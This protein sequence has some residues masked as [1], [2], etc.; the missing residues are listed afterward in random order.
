MKILLAYEAE[1]MG[2]SKAA[3]MLIEVFTAMGFLTV[4]R[5]LPGSV[6]FDIANRNGEGGNAQEVVKLASD[7]A[8][9]GWAWSAT[10]H[11]L[12]VE[13]TP[14]DP[15]IEEFNRALSQGLGMAPVD[16]D[17]IRYGSLSCG[18]TNYVLR[19]IGASMPSTCPLLSQDGR[20]SLALL[21]ER[22]PQYADAVREGLR[23]RTLSWK[24]RALYP[25]ALHIMQGALN[26][27]GHVQRKENE[28]QGL[29]QLHALAS[30]AMARGLEP[31]WAAIKRSVLRTRPPFAD[32]VDDMAAFLATRSGGVHGQ[33]LK[34]LQAF[35]RQFVNPSVRASVPAGLYGALADFPY[36]YLAIAILQVALTC[37]LEFVKHGLCSWVGASEV[38]RLGRDAQRQEELRAAEAVLANARLKLADTGLRGDIAVDNKLTAVFGRLDTMMGRFV[39]R[40]A[41]KK[42]LETP[43][44]GGRGFIDD[45]LAN[46]PDAD[47]SPYHALWPR[48][49]AEADADNGASRP[50]ANANAMPLY[51]VDVSGAVVDPRAL[52]RQKGFE[53][54]VSC[55]L[56]GASDAYR[57]EAVNAVPPGTSNHMVVL[58]PLGT[59]AAAGQKNEALAEFTANWELITARDVIEAHPGW[60]AKYTAA[61]D[62][63]RA[64]VAKGKILMAAGALVEHVDKLCRP[65]SRLS[66]LSKPSRA[67]VAKEK[68]EIGGLVLTPTTTSLKNVP[69]SDARA[70]ENLEASAA[71]EV[72]FRPADTADAYYLLPAASAESVAPMWCVGTT[73][74]ETQANMT[75]AKYVVQALVA[76]DF[77]GDVAPVACPGPKLRVNAKKKMAPGASDATDE[78]TETYVSIPVLINTV[79]V[80]AGAPLLVHRAAVKR[81][82]EQGPTPIT[83]KKVAQARAKAD[84]TK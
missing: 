39:L 77:V 34:Y 4:Q 27:G 42:T 12:C 82:R 75:W 35:H 6:G 67:V 24:V 36:Q 49:P 56:R 38:T 31:D 15:T 37:P 45:L 57:L 2:V 5:I 52:L 53:I 48:A 9:L 47:P 32:S 59:V 79:V 20:Y 41:V 72:T 84:P 60:P 26:V 78:A 19:C 69:L 23:W 21:A 70:R 16:G 55:R 8:Y 40:K 65:A 63:F 13:V 74:E 3:D 1:K 58:T 29:L 18:H 28:I 7:I 43:A 68:L 61:S 44:C 81:E 33:Y 64:L 30:A 50:A 25:K 76:P 62:V 73:T 14:G 17:S 22:D 51:S 10:A 54:G 66:V 80:E 11:A 83:I 46:Y 71:V